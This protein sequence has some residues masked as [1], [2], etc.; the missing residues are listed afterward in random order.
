MIW[1]IHDP[2]LYN[3]DHLVVKHLY[4]ADHAAI[5]WFGFT[6]GQTLRD[7]VTTSVAIIQVLEGIVR[8]N[9]AVEQVLEAGQSVQLEANEHHALTAIKNALVQLVLVPHPQY[10]SLAKEVDLPERR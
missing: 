7:H 10:H 3:P 8:L 4:D 6:A 1:N 5:V 2:E 9:A